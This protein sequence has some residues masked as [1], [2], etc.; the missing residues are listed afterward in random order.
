MLKVE[1]KML[2]V[3]WALGVPNAVKHRVDWAIFCYDDSHT[4]TYVCFSD[5]DKHSQ[6]FTIINRQLR[7]VFETIQR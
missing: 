1:T 3:Y 2:V 5:Q 6:N 7:L 4:H